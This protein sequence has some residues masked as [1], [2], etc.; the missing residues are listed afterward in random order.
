MPA[1][2]LKSHA[3][4]TRAQERRTDDVS[5]SYKIRIGALQRARGETAPRL[6]LHGPT[7][8]L[9]GMRGSRFLVLCVVVLVLTFQTAAH[10]DVACE[11]IAKVDLA[12]STLPVPGEEP[13]AFSNGVACPPDYE[14][15]PRCEWRYQIDL[16]LLATPEPSTPLRVL[17]VF[18]S[19]ARGSGSWTRVIAYRCERGRLLAAFS[20]RFECGASVIRAFGPSLL[21]SVPERGCGTRSRSRRYTWSA[22]GRTYALDPVSGG[23]DRAVSSDVEAGAALPRPG[24]ESP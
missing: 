13:L 5:G 6:H 9:A 21:L 20:E 10:S 19:H 24:G 18:A 4:R 3:F 15:E 16:D 12:N 17:I 22:Q 7:M 14:D 23:N 1:R 8:T 11:D 2:A